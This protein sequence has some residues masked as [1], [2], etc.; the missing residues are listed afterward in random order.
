MDEMQQEELTEQTEES[1]ESGSLDYE[2]GVKLSDKIKENPDS[3]EKASL[4]ELDKFEKFIY[5]G[6]QYTKADLE[7][8]PFFQSD[9]TKKTQEIA[10]ERKF[11]DNLEAD[12]DAISKNPSLVDEFKK[13]YPEKFHGMLRYLNLEQ[14]L[15]QEPSTQAVEQAKP[16][17]INDPRLEELYEHYQ[18]TQQEAARTRID[19]YFDK[20]S[21]KYPQ[22]D[23]VRVTNTLQALYEAHE[24]NPNK[25]ARPDEKMIEKVFKSEND[26]VL[27]R[28]KKWQSETFKSQK[29]ANKEGAGPSAGG[30]IPGR[31]PNQARTIKEATRM[32]MQDPEFS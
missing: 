5:R 1:Q 4:P 11:Y 10:R 15:K 16:E 6:K 27:D 12:L 19:S 31:A 13:I 24:K 22:A 2:E 23:E 8:T 18:N 29:L 7:K 21:T 28:F 26:L 25:Y 14:G 17:A 3:L 30:G 9:Y 20:F 32:A